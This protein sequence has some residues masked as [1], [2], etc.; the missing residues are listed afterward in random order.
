MFDLDA[1]ILDPLPDAMQAAVENH[2]RML[3]NTQED[4]ELLQSVVETLLRWDAGDVITVAFLGGTADLHRKIA[5]AASEW[6]KHANVQFDFG[7]RAG[8]FRKWSSSDRQYT[9]D[10]R[11]AF[12]A[13]FQPGN[14]SAIGRNSVEPSIAGPGEPSMNFGGFDR[15]LP[16][17][18]AATVMHEFG[19]A[20]GFQHE[21]AHPMGGCDNEFRWNDDPGYRR[22][23]G[24]NGQ[25]VPDA[26]GRRPGIYTVLAGPPNRWS[27]SKV[28]HNLKQL[29]SSNAFQLGAFDRQSIMKYSFPEWMFTRGTASVCFTPRNVTLSA[30]DVEGARRAYPQSASEVREAAR[31]SRETLNAALPAA[32]DDIGAVLRRRLEKLIG[33]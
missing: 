29:R 24:T 11:I 12:D 6:A 9:A 14:W 30:G 20:L 17:Q 33:V 2:H 22:T 3:A 18:Y 23:V 26:A 15:R 21:H 27:K 25:L 32:D 19:H 13:E 5:E 16:E 1:L 10:I 8:A 4:P 7:E 31:R 28:D